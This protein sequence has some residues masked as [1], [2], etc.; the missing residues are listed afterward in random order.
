MQLFISVRLVFAITIALASDAKSLLLPHA[1]EAR[2]HT[3]RQC[4]LSLNRTLR[5]T[6]PRTKE[7]GLLTRRDSVALD[8]GERRG[9]VGWEWAARVK[10][11]KAL[12]RSRGV[13]FGSAR[14]VVELTTGHSTAV[15]W[16]F[17]FDKISVVAKG[18]WLRGSRSQ[19]WET[20]RALS[21]SQLGPRLLWPLQNPA[22]DVEAGKRG[23]SVYETKQLAIT[24]EEFVH[25]TAVDQIPGKNF[26]A[27]PIAM[28]TLGMMVAK[29][30]MLPFKWTGTKIL[31]GPLT[32]QDF[33]FCPNRA[34]ATLRNSKQRDKMDRMENSLQ[35]N[36]ASIRRISSFVQ[37]ELPVL[38]SI[39][40]MLHSSVSAVSAYA[41]SSVSAV[42]A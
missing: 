3:L 6:N 20:A 34:I 35:K 4:T 23:S 11:A 30:H 29:L 21:D 19:Q 31:Q 7:Q 2:V 18:R 13:D 14:E 25:G 16:K 22:N 12:A 28:G 37:V 39:E 33:G 42:S 5:Q 15:V 17:V 24:V 10:E 8:T 26:L 41:T 9:L 36:G 32:C 27:D 40:Y 1:E 38:V